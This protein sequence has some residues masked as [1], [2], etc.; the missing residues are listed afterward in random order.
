MC[1]R[2]SLYMTRVQR[3]RFFNE[4]DYVRLKDSYSLDADKM[5]LARKDLCV[6]HPL[7]RVNE[8]CIRDSVGQGGG[9]HASGGD[10]PGQ[11]AG[12]L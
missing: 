2:D 3:E 11:H 7:P 8:M 5:R 1:I 9:G 10:R 4:A 12:L 6:L